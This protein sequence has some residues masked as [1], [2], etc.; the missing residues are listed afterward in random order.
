LFGCA[1]RCTFAPV[2]L[3]AMQ[4]LQA[5]VKLLLMVCSLAASG[6]DVL[7]KK[8]RGLVSCCGPLPDQLRLL[9]LSVLAVW[10]R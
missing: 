7:Q 6:L 8:V 4:A 10:A 3:L 5:F 9:A 2:P 1:V